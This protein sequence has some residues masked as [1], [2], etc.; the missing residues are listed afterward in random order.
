M[1]LNPVGAVTTVRF[2]VAEP[3]PRFVEHTTHRWRG[4]RLPR[5]SAVCG[6]PASGCHRPGRQNAHRWLRAT[7]G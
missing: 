1:N 7:C 5:R 4:D 6:R 3:E 2:G